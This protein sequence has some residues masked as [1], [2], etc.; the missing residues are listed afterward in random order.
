MCIY[1][2]ADHDYAVGIG[3]MTLLLAALL[4]LVVVVILA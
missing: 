3:C 2:Q 4:A 1:N